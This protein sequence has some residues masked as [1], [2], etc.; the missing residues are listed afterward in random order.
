[1]YPL[2]PKVKANLSELITQLVN[3]NEKWI[4]DKAIGI[5]NKSNYW[6]LNYI[7]GKESV[8]HTDYASLARGV[9][10][11]KTKEVPA[12]PL[13]LI[14]SLPFIRFFNQ[15][16]PTAAKIEMTRSDMTEKLDGTMVG[17]FYDKELSNNPQWQTRKMVSSDPQDT[18]MVLTSF[19]GGQ[20]AFMPLIGS[21]VNKLNL[22]PEDKDNTLVFEFIHEASKVFTNYAPA[23]YGLYLIGGRR[24]SDLSE[25][26]EVELDAIAKRIGAF[27]GQHFSVVDPSK[28]GLVSTAVEEAFKS[29]KDQRENFEGF[30]FR[31]RLTGS[32]VKLKD[33]EYV[34]KHALL[35]CLSLKN[36][37]PMVLNEELEEIQA[38]FPIAKEMGAKITSKIDN[39]VSTNSTLIAEWRAKNLSGKEL[40]QALKNS[41]YSSYTV[42]LL[43]QHAK[44]DRTQD[45]A[46][47]DIPNE[48]KELIKTT[49]LGK[50]KKQPQIRAV[51][52]MLDLREQEST[53]PSIDL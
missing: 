39:F 28:P 4:T 9:V 47:A 16:E 31:D 42:G 36:L 8:E 43:F 25:Y 15:S 33:P 14:V 53:T 3:G 13:S 40:A 18:A 21:Y 11:R 41:P 38:Y 20:F 30:V 24:M 44:K 52:E 17:V 10:I 45:V 37:L 34:Q 5:G 26:S 49:A 46:T 7:Q 12:D 50:D 22:A 29:M 48:L 19:Q 23:E 35:G 51:V 1:M 32:R 2:A 6:I 27:R